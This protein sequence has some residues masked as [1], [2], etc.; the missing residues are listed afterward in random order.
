MQGVHLP[1]QAGL[2]MTTDQREDDRCLTAEPL[3]TVTF[4]RVPSPVLERDPV[5]A[6]GASF[7]PSMAQPSIEQHLAR[8]SDPERHGRWSNVP[9]IEDSVETTTE[10][11]RNP[12]Q[13]GSRPSLG[14]SSPWL[15][16]K[17]AAAYVGFCDKTIRRACQLGRLKCA[18]VGRRIRIRRE[19]LD[20]WVIAHSE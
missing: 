13:D 16:V 19:W 4:G 12:D 8:P 10:N 3:K 18:R 15:T 20:D 7:V 5:S 11:Y 1:E 17:E 2:R 9:L 6:L 14:Q